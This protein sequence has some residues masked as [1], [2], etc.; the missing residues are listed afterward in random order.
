LLA[1]YLETD[2]TT[3]LCLADPAF[4]VVAAIGL[5]MTWTWDWTGHAAIRLLAR[6]WQHSRSTQP[7]TEQETRR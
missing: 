2:G 7:K 3:S 5:G 4:D 6:A 1:V